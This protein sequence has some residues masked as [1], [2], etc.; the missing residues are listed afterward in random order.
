MKRIILSLAALAASF[1]ITAQTRTGVVDL[2]A[3]FVRSEP[4]SASSLETQLLMGSVV[5]ILGSEDSWLQIRSHTP[6]YTGWVNGMTVFEMSQEETEAYLES[7]KYICTTEHTFLY[8]R[9]ALQ[10]A[11]VTDLV[12]GDL[13]C[14]IGS[15][16]DVLKTI[17]E[18]A[19]IKVQTPSGKTGYV[20]TSEV[21]DFS[22]WAGD[23]QASGKS[24]LQV[25]ELMI[26]MPYVWGGNTTNGVDCSGLAWLSYFMNGIILPRNA[27]EQ[28]LCGVEVPLPALQKGD[29][30]FFGTKA[31][32]DE[33]EKITHVAIYEGEATIIQSSFLVRKNSLDPSDATYYDREVLHARRILGHVDDGTGAVSVKSSPWFFYKP[34]MSGLK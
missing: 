5:E 25:A 20:K 23:V 8:E 18:V 1:S 22:T 2:S 7:S 27:S 6:E 14:R 9:P 16:S 17:R 33:P 10:S 4:N 30:L 29:L 24:V 12:M 13:L 19:F 26:G 28:A 32:G 21:T 31:D 15:E 3:A 11:R 34:G